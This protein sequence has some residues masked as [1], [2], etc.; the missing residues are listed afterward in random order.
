MK[1]L[2]GGLML[3]AGILICLTSGLCSVWFLGMMLLEP[4]QNG[5]QDVLGMIGMVSVFGGVPFGIGVLL[6]ALGRR[7]TRTP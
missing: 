1:A 7:L 4:N 5:A 2:L 3:A 6:F